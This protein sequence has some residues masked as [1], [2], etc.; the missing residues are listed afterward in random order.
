MLCVANAPRAEL[1]AVLGHFLGFFLA[2]GP[3]Q[4][5]GAAQR[6]AA[7]DLRGLHHLLLVD[8]DAVG[9]GQHLGHGRVRVFNGL[10]AVLACHKA[11]DQVHRA[12]AVQRV[13]CDQV[14]QPRRLGVAQHALHAAAFKLEHGLGAPVGKEAVGLGVVQRNVLEGELF[15]ALVATHD[16]LAGNLQD[17]QGGQAQE[18]E[19]HQA[20]RLHVIL[21]VLAHG[22]VAARL[23][24]ERAEIGE[25]ARRDQY[26]AGVHAN[27]AGHAFELLRQRQK[28]LD[29][30]LLLQPLGQHRLGLDGPIDGDVLARLVRNQLAD[31][32]AEGVAHVQARGPTS[33]IAARAAMVPKVTI[34]LTAS[35]PYLSLT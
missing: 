16:E 9:L 24:V 6:V 30:V 26:A 10:T 13:Q 4:Q 22:R 34:W 25:L 18:V 2:H 5:V 20:D 12:R 1:L 3:A 21:V 14:F 27:V 17:G 19:L 28:R 35:L 33:R 15:L 29:L 31:A 7:Q 32:I 23:L 8:H 11:R